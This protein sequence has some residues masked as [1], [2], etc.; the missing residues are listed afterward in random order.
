[1]PRKIT[2]DKAFLKF[3]LCF[4]CDK[5][6]ALIETCYCCILY[7]DNENVSITCLFTCL[8][9]V[10]TGVSDDFE[11]TIETEQAIVG[12]KFEL[13]CTS[14]GPVPYAIRWKRN[15]EFIRPSCK[16]SVSSNSRKES[17]LRV[18]N[19]TFDDNGTY[20]CV[21]YSYYTTKVPSFETS[22]LVL[23]E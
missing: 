12:M 23:G 2:I 14:T 7:V 13:K 22:V 11:V 17:V 10:C 15:N 8:V 9:Y 18:H 1:M 16:Y 5:L 20:V 4:F 19:T 21:A 3:C 6:H